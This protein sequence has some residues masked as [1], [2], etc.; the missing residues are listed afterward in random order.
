MTEMTAF[1][2]AC[3]FLIPSVT[4]LIFL[5][6]YWICTKI[7]PIIIVTVTAVAMSIA[8]LYG[9]VTL[10]QYETLVQYLVFLTFAILMYRID[11]IKRKYALFIMSV[12]TFMFTVFGIIFLRTFWNIGK[13]EIEIRQE[14]KNRVAWELRQLKK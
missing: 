12:F 4:I 1:G 2:V 8:F 9:K 14:V 11:H 10:L 3:F 5:L 13:E 7:P 6:P